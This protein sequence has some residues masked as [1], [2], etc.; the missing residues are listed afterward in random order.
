[1]KKMQFV[2]PL[3]DVTVRL[4]Q[5]EKKEDSL[6]IRNVLRGLK[7]DR[8]ITNEIV[9]GIESEAVN[10]GE[11]FRN[12]RQ[13]LMVIIF[14][15]WSCEEKKIEVFAHEKRHLE[16]RLME[17][18]GVEDIESAGLLAGWLGVQFRKFE[19]L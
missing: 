1:M 15:K 7:T 3:Y 4:Y 10:G 18:F 14:Y 8:D 12:L 2:I 17:Y 16:D 6:A 19:R 5:V 9:S 11:T 13:R